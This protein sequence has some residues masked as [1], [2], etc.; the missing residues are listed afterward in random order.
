MAIVFIS[1]KERQKTLI[2]S[3]VG[4]FVIILTLISLS[5]F[6][7]KSKETPIEQVFQAPEIRINFDVLK[8]DKITKL[9][10]LP[11]LRKEF[12][13]TGKNSKGE[14]KAGKISSISEE[15]A[16]KTLTELGLSSIT[17]E[18]ITGGRINPFT[19]Y[20]ETAPPPPVTPPRRP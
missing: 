8:S 11:E 6:L 19:P 9:D 17:L 2:V 16:M 7:S 10:F 14:A 3:I 4:F 1:P 12:S 15:E 5:V 13:Y 20:Y 18:E